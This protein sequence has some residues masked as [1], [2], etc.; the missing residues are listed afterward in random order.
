MC[1]EYDLVGFILSPYH[2]IMDEAKN[3]GTVIKFHN[4]VKRLITKLFL[5]KTLVG[6]KRELKTAQIIKNLR[7]EHGQFTRHTGVFDNNYYWVIAED[8]KVSV[9][10]LHFTFFRPITDILIRMGCIVTS[11]VLCIGSA[12]KRWKA[13]KQMKDGKRNRLVNGHMGNQTVVYGKYQQQKSVLRATAFDLAG[14][15]WNDD[16]FKC[17]N[18]DE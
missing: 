18:M 2:H 14:R 13:T 15:L 6:T 5:G 16:D 11:K 9:H 3:H 4:A 12:E 8:P 1:H 17:C 10:A 7:A